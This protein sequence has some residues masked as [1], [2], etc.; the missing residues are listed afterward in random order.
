MK[1]LTNSLILQCIYTQH[2]PTCF[3]T[4][5][6][7]HRGDNHDPAE[8][9]VQCCRNWRWMEAVHCSRWHDGQKHWT[10]T[11]AWSW[12]SP[13][14][15]Y[16]RVPKRVGEFRVSMNWRINAFFGLFI[17]LKKMHGPK[18]KTKKYISLI[19]NGLYLEMEVLQ[20]KAIPK[21]F[22]KLSCSKYLAT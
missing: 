17:H 3:G 10:H 6:C 4:I 18:F 21:L 1:R 5:K 8:L 2:F 20:G 12:L 14:W 19:C 11:L 7:Y 9:G 16:F 15:W 13:W 22:L